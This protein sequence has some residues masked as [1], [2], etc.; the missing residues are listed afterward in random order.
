MKLIRRGDEARLRGRGWLGPRL[1]DATHDAEH[2]LP[3]A[4]DREVGHGLREEAASSKL[5]REHLDR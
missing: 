2:D 1:Q 5:E 4:L 3:T